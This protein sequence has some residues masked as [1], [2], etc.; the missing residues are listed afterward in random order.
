VAPAAWIDKDGLYP[1]DPLNAA[2]TAAAAE[3][4]RAA[5]AEAI[6]S[7]GGELRFNSVA[8]R[9][10]P[11]VELAAWKAGVGPKPARLVD[12]CVVLPGSGRAHEVALA[13]PSGGGA[14]EVVSSKTLP[15][16]AQPLLSPAD[17]ELAEEVAKGDAR[18][19]E[20]LAERYGITDLALVAA[21]P[22]SVHVS[23]ADW[24][25]L[26]WRD[27]GVAPRLVQT[28]LYLR[29][30]ADDNHYAHPIDLLPVVDLNARK[31]VHIDMQASAPAI[32]TASVNYH[33]NKL[34]NNT[35][36]QSMWRADVLKPLDVVQREG[37]SFRVDGQQ[38]TWDKWSFRVGWNHREGL[39]LHEMEYDGRSVVNRASLVEMAVPY[40][41]PKEPFTRKC[42]FDVG[43][44]GLGN[45]ANSLELGC[46]C[47]GHIHYFDGVL[48]DVD[49]APRELRKAICMHEEDDGLLWKHVEYRN[50][51]NESR[52]SRK[53]VVS[54][55]ATVVNY[56]YLF[57]WYLKQDG[58]IEYEIRLS[59]ELSTNLLSEGEGSAPSHGVIVAP[60]VNAQTHQHMFCAR[61][62]MAVDGPANS[63]A[64]IDVV[65]AAPDPVA[66]PA[67]NAFGPVVT[68]LRSEAE[69]VRVAAPEK[70]RTW[71]V[72]NSAKL[73]PIS[74]KPVGY[75]LVP[76]TIGAA[77]PTL[78][79][80]PDCAVTARGEFATKHLWVT[81]HDDAERWP[82][83]EFTVQ[84]AGGD[85]L[86]AWVAADRPLV[87][88][89]IVLW[90]CF[91]VVH[92]PRPEDF[93]VMPCEM[94]G[95]ALKPDGF[96]TGNPAVDL[97]PESNAASKQCCSSS[98]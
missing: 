67:G 90:H 48:V 34:A 24:A 71:V 20:L 41:D 68:P 25:P 52:R 26:G 31:V 88:A 73:N 94:T 2:E 38:V 57:Y 7:A 51:H 5:L 72:Q 65:A 44:Y 1:L 46:D 62:D 42:A 95:F 23:A 13:L 53:L 59:G 32:P 55:I 40:A 9:E 36:L 28:F 29:H 12:V 58:T 63:V 19:A 93:P 75:K 61:L 87:D 77:Q 85:G 21:D 78:L 33:R 96:F 76:F 86:P 45:C 10:P 83:G 47:L 97:P 16:D 66:N 18:V 82:A 49:G 30:D 50:G 92:V 79:T 91:G 15:A 4:A 80:G 22:W 39:V 37:P 74:G 81:A 89:D 84:S 70:A 27:D 98:D 43:D 6:A 69:A 11:K 8:L 35:Y 54:F 60:G 14:P 3:G 64:E 56:E 17:C